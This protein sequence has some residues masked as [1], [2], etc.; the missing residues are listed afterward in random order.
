MKQ[1]LKINSQFAG[2]TVVRKLSTRH[3]GV[4][5][6]YLTKSNAVVDGMADPPENLAILTV[7]NLKSKRYEVDGSSRKRVPDFI[8][9]VK[10]LRSRHS[11]KYFPRL[12]DCGI[13]KVGNRRLGWMLQP[14]ID[15]NSL[16]N[17][18]KLQ[19][20]LCMPDV[21]KVMNALFSAV[22]ELARYTH[23]GGHYNINTDN[24][25][26]DYDGDELKGVY[27]IG[28]S[29]MGDPYHGST[30]FTEES[31][32]NR[33]RAPETANGVFSHLTDIYAL[34]MVMT[35]MISG[36]VGEEESATTDSRISMLSSM[37]F[38][39]QFMKR[40]RNKLS[41]PQRL[42]LEKA[43]HAN[44]SVRFQTVERF[45][46]FV[47]KL[48]KGNISTQTHVER[49]ATLAAGGN[50]SVI[51]EEDEKLFESLD[52]EAE[53]RAKAQDAARKKSIKG[54]DEVAGMSELKALFRRDFIRIVR[55]PKV[56]QA[57]GIKPSNCTLLYGPQGCGKTFI[58]EK[59]AQESGLNYKI[60][61]PSELGSIYIHGSQQKIAEL[62]EE[63]E[64][65]GPMI[66]IFDE[67]DA[68]VPKRDADLNVN[69]ANEVN[70]MLTQ[71]NN[72][73]SRGIY[74]LA[75]TN[76]PG[77]LD[78][79]IMRKGRVDR[80]VYVSLPDKEARKELFR[81]EIEKRPFVN[82]DYEELASVTENFTCSDISFIVEETARLCFEETLDQGLNEPL[83]LS[84][85]RLMEVIKI[86]LP[87]VSDKQRKE[88]L[89][90][91]NK[92]ENRQSSDERKRV[93]YVL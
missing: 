34:G 78:P 54:L 48:A 35:M 17:E 6:V 90:L 70:E 61:N 50:G 31:Q 10:F 69:Q 63:A 85:N 11:D 2:R 32:D 13:E 81:L 45:R 40:N 92:M 53:I 42:I 19:T 21:V 84:M 77:L 43:T 82:I 51:T 7:F 39:E 65:K 1:L 58:A 5:E 33:F 20:G 68:I 46:S 41:A 52:R 57:Y 16:T 86:T 14:Q 89:D 74:V 15:A 23:G 93:G 36:D 66:L 87:S 49:A 30:P 22:N 27:L 73:A 37:E 80:T 8:E 91:K 28:L 76:R 12:I 71:L 88:Y 9:E 60:I 26:L 38:R 64:K 25:L 44:P 47:G 75:T 79:A 18:I 24:I 72:C 4:R 83:P 67:F 59:A 56:A 3:D 29:D 55:N 62:F